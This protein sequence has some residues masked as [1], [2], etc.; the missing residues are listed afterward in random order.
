M[1]KLL[2]QGPHFEKQW[3]VAQDQ[4]TEK[5]L[6]KTITIRTENWDKLNTL[7]CKTEGKLLEKVVKGQ[8]PTGGKS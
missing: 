2:V 5:R 1:L 3:C 4:K 6:K 8:V 7:F